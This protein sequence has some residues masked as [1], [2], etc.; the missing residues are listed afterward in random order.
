MASWDSESGMAFAELW[1][2]QL[3]LCKTG[4]VIGID[5][6]KSHAVIDK[7]MDNGMGRKSTL[8]CCIGKQTLKRSGQLAFLSKPQS[9]A[10]K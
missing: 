6:D 8:R 10:S 1:D 4:G 9:I 5:I 2:M 3:T 7:A